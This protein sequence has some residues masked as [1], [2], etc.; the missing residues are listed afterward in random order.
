LYNEGFN[1][2]GKHGSSGGLFSR[3]DDPNYVAD[4]EYF[5]TTQ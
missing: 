3:T 1:K 2:H 4:A 5:R